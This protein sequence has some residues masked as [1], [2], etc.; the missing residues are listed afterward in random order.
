MELAYADGQAA[1]R[2]VAGSTKQSGSELQ[3]NWRIEIVAG[4]LK[5]VKRGRY[6]RDDNP[7]LEKA[8]PFPV[9]WAPAASIVPSVWAVGCDGQTSFPGQIPAVLLLA[10]QP[11]LPLL[12]LFGMSMRMTSA[13][14]PD[15]P[16]IAA[17]PKANA[18]VHRKPGLPSNKTT[19]LSRKPALS[20]TRATDWLA[21]NTG[22]YWLLWLI[23]SSH[24]LPLVASSSS[25]ASG[26]RSDSVSR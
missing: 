20:W 4:A 5:R 18:P 8:C 26:N 12:L 15:V 14:R 24:G 2:S 17:S 9:G 6:L 25:S 23:R 1:V 22:N 21:K 3:S 13:A 16:S 19:R 7:L 11:A 10:F